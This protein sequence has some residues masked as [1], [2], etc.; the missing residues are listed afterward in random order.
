M[1]LVLPTLTAFTSSRL[2]AILTAKTQADFTTAFDALFAHNVNV[3]Y[4]GKPVSREQYQAQLLSQSSAALEEQGASVS[5]QGE[6]EVP[7]DK[8]QISGLVGLFYTSL[9]DSKFLVLGAPAESKVTSSFNAIIQATEPRPQS[10]PRIRG[11]FDPRRIV[12]VNQIA[13][14]QAVHVTIPAASINS[15]SPGVTTTENVTLGPGPRKITPGPFGG[16][17][18]PGPVR[19]GP[20]ETNPERETFPGD[21]EFGVG[22]VVIPGETI[23]EDTNPKA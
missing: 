2:M 13:T 12:T 16:H 8:G 17:F 1:A 9:V 10:N 11:Y 22:P 4:N 14:D 15:T 19:L 3:I 6:L 23:G 5:V 20:L 18:G 7:G 21:G